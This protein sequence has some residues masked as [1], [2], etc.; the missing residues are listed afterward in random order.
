M[1]KR[2]SIRKITLATFTLLVLTLM[3][4]LPNDTKDL[5]VEQTEQYVDLDTTNLHEIYLLD[6]NNYIART[7]IS[8]VNSDNKSIEEKVK[9][10]LD[11]MIIGGKKE[12]LIPNGFKA[13]IPVD[14][15]ILGVTFNDGTL[16]ID[17][18]KDILDINQEYEEKMIESICYTLTSIKEVKGILIYVEGELLTEL[19][20]SKKFLPTI[21]DRSFGINKVFNITSLKDVEPVTIYYVNKCNDNYYYVPVTKYTNNTDDKVKVIIEELA[22]TPTYEN[23]LMS[24]LNSNTELINYEI[25]D[26]QM[27]LEFNNYLIDDIDKMNILEEVKYTISLS[28]KDN[29][30]IDEILFY[31]DNEEI[32]KTVFSEQ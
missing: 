31:V 1:L 28:I 25:K 26:K 5:K 2:I 27:K 8:Y 4:L 12:S 11:A 20:K 17:F 21:L 7:T 14:T 32:E 16:K 22:G 15:R 10:L 19:P 18:S 23:N 13:I 9:E 3:Y 29:F 30:D 6:K 24:F